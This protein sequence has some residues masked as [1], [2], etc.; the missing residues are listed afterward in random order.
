M[1]LTNPL[2]LRDKMIPKPD[3]LVPDI[4]KMFSDKQNTAMISPP[5]GSQPVEPPKGEEL[6]PLYRRVW[7]Q[8]LELLKSFDY[9]VNLGKSRVPNNIV[10]NDI[11][12]S[13][14]NAIK[15]ILSVELTKL[16]STGK[17]KE[18]YDALNS[19]FVILQDK[20]NSEQ[21]PERKI[22]NMRVLSGLHGF[23]TSYVNSVRNIK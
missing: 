14:L 12:S 9:G 1:S 10:L 8:D 6:N 5:E 2:N 19:L 11:F 4:L 7:V 18:I 3:E 16:N 23:I 20:C 22:N 13:L 21:S 15:Q 17:Y